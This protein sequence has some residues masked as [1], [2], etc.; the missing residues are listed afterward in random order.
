MPYVGRFFTSYMLVLL[1]ADAARLVK[2]LQTA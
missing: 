2:V 1:A